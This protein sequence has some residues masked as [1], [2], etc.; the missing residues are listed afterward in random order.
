MATKLDSHLFEKMREISAN[1]KLS[2]SGLSLEYYADPLFQVDSRNRVRVE[3]GV[4][5]ISS[6][7]D[8]MLTQTGFEI[9]YRNE[10][11]HRY[12]G[13]LPLTSVID[14]ESLSFVSF[15]RAIERP[16]VNVTSEGDV[17][18][19][20]D[21]ARSTWGV[22]GN[23]RRVGIISDGVSHLE[24]S[25]MAG[26]LPSVPPVQVVNNRYTG[27]EGT[28]MLEIV[29]DLAPGSF[30]SFAD[31][32]SS[33]SDFA[34]N[35]QLLWQ[36]GCQVICDD[37]VYFHEPAFEDGIVAQKVNEISNNGGIYVSSATN[38]RESHY[39]GDYYNNGNNWNRFNLSTG[40]S[41][42]IQ[43]TVPPA[44]TKTPIQTSTITLQWNDKYG[45]SSS[46][47]DLYLYDAAINYV[48]K[49]STTTQN[50]NADPYEIIQV[51]N[52]SPAS[53]I[54]NVAVLNSNG[55]APVRKLQLWVYNATLESSAQVF[56][57]S[58]FG[59]STASGCI[60]VAAIDQDS[61]QR[62]Y[63][64]EGPALIYSFD[65]T[66]KPT[67]YSQR[68]K[69]DLSALDGVQ[70]YIGQQGYFSNP[71]YGT[72]AAAPH[73]A[74]VAA[75]VW[76]AD[77]SKPSSTIRFT[78]ESSAINLP[79]STSAK[80]NQYGEGC[81]DAYNALSQLIPLNPIPTTTSITPASKNAGDAQF[82]MTVNGTNFL[83]TSKVR[84]GGTDRTTSYV[85]STQL[86]ATIPASDMTTAE[87]YNITV[88]NPTP[89]GG[90]SNAQIFMVIGTP[91]LVL[92][93][94]SVTMGSV[95][96]N[97]LK[98]DTVTIWNKGTDT[99]KITNITS[100]NGQYSASPTVKNI[101][102]NGS[103]IDTIKF[104]PTSIGSS[105]TKILIASNDVTTPDTI[106]VSGFCSGT[107]NLV[108]SRSSV[109]MGNIT[110]NTLKTDTVTIWNKGTDTLKIAS[111]TSTNGQYSASP[112][113][114]NIPPNGSL[115]DT[116]KFIP[117]SIG[118]SITKI[119]IASNDVTTPD[120]INVNGSSPM[121]VLTTL[122]TS[123][124]YSNVAK[125][126][127]KRDTIKVVNS[128]VNTLTVD[129][130]Y[131]KTS[132]FAV[133]RINGT[134]GTDT[135][136]V[137]VSFAP[138]A[139]ASYTDTLY[140]RNNSA[141]PLVKIP[142]SGNSP[143]PTFLC[144]LTT[145]SFGDVGIYDSAKT[146]LK[147]TNSS[148]N[149]LTIDSIYTHSSVF[150]SLT[151]FSQA[152]DKDTATMTVWFKPVTFG[153]FSDTL[154]LRNDSDTTLFRIPLSGR[155]PNSS[156]SITPSSIAFGTVK[157]DSTKQL[158]FTITNSSISVLQIDSFYTKTK[159]FNVTK[160]LAFGNVKQGDTTKVAIRF[161]PDSLRSY[162]DTM[163]IANN[164][165]A[166]P[167][168]V[169][170]S[171]NGT[172]TGIQEV[173]A[174]TPTI[175]SLAQNYPNPYNPS[176]TIQYGLPVRSTVRLVIYNILGQVIKELV[177]IEQQA[178]IQSV[179]W[180][181]NVASGLYFYRLEATSKDNSS[182]RFV[183]TKKML[184]LK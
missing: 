79:F 68:T 89:G 103:L 169:P 128:S 97:T 99:L 109:T 31:E 118:S 64:S 106:N 163:Y 130:I 14:I 123:I 184:L 63:S 56:G 114:K 44:T 71:F 36:G 161:T 2:V 27:D 155:T 96:L 150:T 1:G 67:S 129:S 181:A 65:A 48:V 46:D 51:T 158:L 133:D 3:I 87:T 7:Y 156:I 60:S 86:T 144:N 153:V 142:L 126:T 38:F 15:V 166:S 152:T 35:I 122:K 18:H 124:V 22:N 178:G 32:G 135:L 179:V 92:S 164:S 45:Q 17:F 174:E 11:F 8:S 138:I 54:Y 182:K 108:L 20:A 127:T 29:H 125:G 33:E 83:S 120:T 85:S 110:L 76:S 101:P 147:V 26:E 148:A 34:N 72:S 143:T 183:E 4:P 50:G 168:K 176:T 167:F 90:T 132:A 39:I 136:K 113:M 117:T 80:N 173:A 107:P 24:V 9:L 95:T 66:G 93:R 162:I 58:S 100:T 84:L 6:S 134:V 175:Y 102:P 69:P 41:S 42:Y 74:A 47:Y 137:V 52:S 140:L 73:V 49:S 180:N 30:L 154:F 40:Y 171:G 53:V 23:N 37:I 131:T 139:I 70:T 57:S 157:K 5:R 75:L 98:T 62:Y 10:A 151:S 82:S 149:I 21:I 88:F 115:I 77:V 94:P 55:A 159:Y 16:L 43:I 105:T 111:I 91:N 177:N 165:L 104:I 59:H 146:I 121:P 141:T 78:L 172:L 145:I 19:R 170:L 112:T 61:S 81:L 25:R 119:L 116:I 13:W 12:D 160:I 28:A